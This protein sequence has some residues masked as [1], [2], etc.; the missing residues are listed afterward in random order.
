MKH[1]KTKSDRE[2]AA[3]KVFTKTAAG[4]IT[5]T[6]E[7]EEKVKNLIDLIRQADE[8]TLA[9]SELK[10]EIKEAMREYGV[11]VSASGP[12]LATWSPGNRTVSIDY[13]AIFAECN[14]PEDIIKKHTTIKQSARK[15]VVEG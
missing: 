2:A 9:A 12:V 15:F 1:I 13:A 11:L 4:T 10:G 7:L 8:L 5:A 14:V 6:P 3:D